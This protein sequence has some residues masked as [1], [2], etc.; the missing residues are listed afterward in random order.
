MAQARLFLCA[1]QF[2]TRL[3]TPRLKGFQPDWIA[4][5][6]PYYPVV[7]WLVGGLSGAAFLAASP[8]WP[9]LPAAVIAIV[10]GLLATGGFHEDGLADAADGLGGGRTPARRLEIMKDSRIGNYGALALWSVLTLKAVLLATLPPWQGALALLLT[11]GAGRAAAA[12][13]MA[14]LTYVRDEDQAKLGPS[15]MAVR[16]P[17]AAIAVALGVAP[18]IL[19][20][21]HL[22]AAAG[23]CLA[24]IGATVL[25]LVSRRLI[26]GFT[27]DVLGAIEQ[28]VELGLLLGLTVKAL[29]G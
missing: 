27:G 17:E 28:F 24:A 1:L 10:V 11:H 2:M 16:P 25:A 21:S 8:F 29:A 6:A 19:W 7:G 23:L 13:V 12:G 18:M 4:R 5:S 9:G 14:S 15:P 22:H 3:P 20:P 26:G